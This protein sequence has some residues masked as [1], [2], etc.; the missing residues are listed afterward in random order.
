M[1]Q[2]L[3]VEDETFIAE[4]IQDALEE[5]GLAVKS[6]HTDR[7]AYALLEGE[8]RS[9]EV[10]IADVNLGPGTTGFDVARRA[11]ALHPDLKVVY[12]SG[13]AAHLQ[14]QG[15]EGSVMFPKPFYPDELADQIVALMEH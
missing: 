7:S 3:L 15:V 14:K 13:H 1:G 4:M 12:I 9:F 8:A 6:A 5:R 11:R 2:I 10:L